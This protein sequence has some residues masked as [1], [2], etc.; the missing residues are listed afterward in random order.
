MFLL[1]TDIVIYA[2]KGHPQVTGRLSQFADHP[3]Y[4]SISTLMELFYGAY[5]SS[6]RIKNVARIRTL[7]QEFNIIHFDE[8]MA[9]TFGEI[10]A[11]LE[12]QGVPLDDMDIMMAGMAL[13]KNLILVTNNTKH[14]KR[15]QGL[16]LQN[17]CE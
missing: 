10:K 6:Q 17:W 8:A 14:F 11:G 1:N 9:E 5:K 12:D 15:I 13:S 2:L 4:L 16:Q 7:L 3:M